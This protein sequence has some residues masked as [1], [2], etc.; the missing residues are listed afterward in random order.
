[1]A[2]AG[3]A[4]A[5]IS[6]ILE[7][8]ALSGFSPSVS[9]DENVRRMDDFGFANDDSRKQ[10]KAYLLAKLQ[11]LNKQD[12][13]YYD[14]NTN[15]MALNTN[16][17]Q[18]RRLSRPLRRRRPIIHKRPKVLYGILR[19]VP[20]PP[21]R[22]DIVYPY[23]VGG[24]SLIDRLAMG[25]S[26]DGFITSA[27]A[28]YIFNRYIVHL[29][30]I[31]SLNDLLTSFGL[32]RS[33][34]NEL[35]IQTIIDHL[36]PPE[37]RNSVSTNSTLV[38][39]LQG[40]DQGLINLRDSWR[41]NTQENS[42]LVNV[43]KSVDTSLINLSNTTI[44]LSDFRIPV[45]LEFNEEQLEVL[46]RTQ[47][48]IAG[49]ARQGVVNNLMKVVDDSLFEI[50][51][52][53]NNAD[54]DDNDDLED[55]STVVL[56]M[57]A[58]DKGLVKLRQSFVNET[59]SNSTE[60]ALSS[61]STIINH[62]IDMVDHVLNQ[63]TIYS[64]GQE[65]TSVLKVADEEIK[66]IKDYY[67]HNDTGNID[68]PQDVINQDDKSPVVT[69]LKL[70]DQEVLEIVKY[71]TSGNNETQTSSTSTPQPVIEEQEPQQSEDNAVIKVMKLADEQLKTMVNIWQGGTT[72]SSTTTA[73]TTTFVSNKQEEE[74]DSA[75]L[76]F[77]KRVDREV[78]QAQKYLY[79][80][81]DNIISGST[82]SAPEQVQV[83]ELQN[84]NTR[85]API[86]IANTESPTA[87]APSS[88]KDVTNTL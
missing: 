74:E 76:Q 36:H 79:N 84:N 71:F 39:F 47:R 45:R 72:T 22:L 10:R 24:E 12:Y 55:D 59:D 75:F 19:N 52:F 26:L 32:A 67:F 70:A 64:V 21:P 53:L 27:I 1:M 38:N 82:K 46:N 30:P 4:I 48:S 15:Y 43:L 73:K 35:N 49:D 80:V 58:V 86:P 66:D 87:S 31:P 81:T 8:I 33:L 56:L 57:K 3:V 18:V 85:F 51:D 50:R 62:G 17:Q 13:D 5:V 34:N 54:L 61:L 41:L 37:G 44:N 9:G 16:V 83:S 29:L 23:G 2:I 40:L 60:T 25:T 68:L 88:T 20:K 6:M 7:F 28:T 63:T 77:M 78:T 42:T 65:A 14:Y 11:Q 69:I